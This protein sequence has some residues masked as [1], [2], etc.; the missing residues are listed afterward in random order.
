LD[1]YFTAAN[2]V[3]AFKA[4][5]D[6]EHI[7]KQHFSAFIHPNDLQNAYRYFE[8]AKQGRQTDTEL[9]VVT[10]KKNIIYTHL[11]VLPIT[12]NN[13]IVGVYGIANDITDKKIAETD[14]R[15]SNE[16]F[17]YVTKATFDAIWDFQESQE[18]VSIAPYTNLALSTN[19]KHVEFL[20]VKD[21]IVVETDD[22]ILIL[23]RHQ[24]QQVKQVYERLEKEN[25]ILLH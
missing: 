5:T 20:G 10:A 18:S 25:S 8:D 16:R 17:N 23:P 1:G 6:I 13:H 2:A 4:E 11:V 24:S 12:V 7:L 3:L 19:K 22:A 14:L 15:I 21:L 9:R